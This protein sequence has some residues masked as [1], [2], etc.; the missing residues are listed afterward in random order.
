MAGKTK[1]ILLDGFS[2]HPEEAEL[3]IAKNRAGEMAILPMTFNGDLT[4]FSEASS[5]P[6]PLADPA[7][8]TSPPKSSSPLPPPPPDAFDPFA[9][10]D[11]HN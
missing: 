6:E 8:S 9:W 5:F 11:S 7:K 10:K 1:D 3:I 4:K 2:E